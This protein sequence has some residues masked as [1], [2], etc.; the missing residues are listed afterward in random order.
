[1]DISGR[2]K[3]RLTGEDRA[4]LLHAM[5]TNDIKALAPGDGCYV[6]F[7]NAQGR[8]L[9]DAN[10]LC[11]AENLLLDTEPETTAKVYE[12][13][14]KFII[15]DDVALE[16]LT[17][18]T[19]TYALEGPGV[20]A[21]LGDSLPPA[22]GAY[23]V[24]DGWTVTRASLAGSATG[25]LIFGPAGSRP[26][27][28]EGVE[29]ADL[30]ALRVVRLEHG[31]PRYGEEISE[32]FLVQE[33]GQM[34]AVFVPRR[35]VISARK[36]WSASGLEPRST[37]GLLPLGIAG[38]SVPEAGLRLQSAGKDAAELMSAAYSPARQEVVALAYVRVD[39]KPGEVVEDSGFRATVLNEP[40]A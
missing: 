19:A 30:E 1:M 11:G 38:E 10:I 26:A 32:R 14:D 23:I 24:R 7:L 3:I 39:V 22:P 18:V 6:F 12:H 15:A 5:T 27:F 8:I 35:A 17:A 31:K 25:V 4:R 20:A 37:A 29:E 2:G 21:I 13:L 34:G 40:M 36:L 16:D 28:F 9:A 33:T